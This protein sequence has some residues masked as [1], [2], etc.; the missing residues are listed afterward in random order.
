M[1]R[2]ESTEQACL[3]I[4]VPEGVEF[5]ATGPCGVVVEDGKTLLVAPF[6]AQIINW[7]TIPCSFG[8]HAIFN[9]LADREIDTLRT[10]SN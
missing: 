10:I 7:T 1:R 9:P 5:I 6:G 4:Q 3:E 8:H 2:L